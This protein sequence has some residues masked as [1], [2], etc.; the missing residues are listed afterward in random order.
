MM[1]KITLCL[2]F[3][4]CVTN[5]FAS[6]GKLKY[7]KGDLE[8][9]RNRVKLKKIEK[10][11]IIKTG[12]LF[13][14]GKKSIAIIKS[15]NMTTKIISNSLVIIQF[16]TK[17][18]IDILV[19]SG[20]VITNLSAKILGKVNKKT[21]VNV[22]TKMAAIGVRG[23]KFLVYSG[24]PKESILT[25]DRGKVEFQATNSEKAITIGKN[26]STM[27]NKNGKVIKPRDFG[28]GKYVNWE[29]DD[30]TQN[31]LQPAAFFEHI[32]KMWN[33]YKE[34]Q[35]MLW[36]SHKKETQSLWE[37]WIKQNSLFN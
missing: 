15:R 7:Y 24:T 21:E 18:Q 20:G 13:R 9:V 27:V 28:I 11:M 10:G 16:P 34:E 3:S 30:L 8:I 22:Y 17:K 31:L 36:A 25:V 6:V 12:D 19:N 33:S 37:E 23:T 35:E 29:L 4:L 26:S 32:A 14:T 1:L 2:L 5:A